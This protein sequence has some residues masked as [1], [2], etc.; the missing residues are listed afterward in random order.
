MKYRPPLYQP[1]TG[2]LA[3]V[4]L[5][6]LGLGVLALSFMLGLLVLAV[7]VGLAVIASM[8]LMVRRWFHRHDGVDDANDAL[9]V[10]YRVVRR[11]H[12]PDD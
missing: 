5:G 10:E 6:V 11:Q 8:G 9:E 7:V 1:P 4:V 12:F 2:P 3:R